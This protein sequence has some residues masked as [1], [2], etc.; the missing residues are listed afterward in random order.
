MIRPITFVRTSLIRR[1]IPDNGRPTRRTPFLLL[2]VAVLWSA[3]ASAQSVPPNCPA[4][5][6]TAAIID[7]DL[8][9][10]FCELCGPGTIRLEIENPFRRSDDADFSDIVVT[11]D[12]LA[13]GLTYV[14]GTTRFIGVNVATPPAVEPSVSG[15]NG[16][17]LTWTLPGQFVLEGRP[18]GGSGNSRGLIV[19]F[20][21][22]RHAA[23]GEEGLVLANRTIDAQVEFTP[24]CDTGYRH[25]STSGP[26]LLPLNEP[27]PQIIKTGRVVDAGQSSGSYTG[28]IYGHEND[29]AIWRIEVRNNGDA[30]L[31]DLLFSDAMQPGN[32]E[33]DHIC[34]SEADASSAAS[35][36]GTG[37]CVSVGGVTD[38]NDISVEQL[39]DT[40]PGPYIVAPAGGSGFYYLVGR[41]TDSC[42]NRTNTVYDVEWGCEVEPP[43]G[44]IT[45]TST[46]QTAG[47]DALLSTR[48]VAAGLDV[49][50]FLTGTNTSQPMGTKG[51]VRIR[52]RNQTGG[53]IKGGVS[54]LRLRN[55][56]PPEYVVDPTFDPIVR[57]SPAYGNA[58][59]G[60]LDTIEWTNP[61]PGTFPL[62][63]NDPALPLGNIAPEFLV[64]SSDV[65]DDFPDQLNMLRHGDTLNIIF[66]TVLIDPQ[67]YDREAYLDVRE[68][69]PA[70]DPPGTD[71]TETF[72]ID[73]QV[74]IWWEEFCTATEHY[75]QVNQPDTAEPEDIDVDVSGNVLNFILTNTDVL[76]L[77]AELRNRGGHDADDY[78]AYVTFGE[79]MSVQSAPGGCSQT[80][81]P[82]PMPEWQLPVGIPPTATVYE[83]DVGM[84]PAGAQRD[85]TFQVAKNPSPAADD[86]LTFRVDV[87]GEITLSDGT[88]LW[89]PTPQ[90]RGD[91]ITDRANNYTIDALR[92]RVVGYNLLKSQ[93]GVCTENNPPPGIPDSEI[94]IGEECEFHIESG[95]WFGFDTP[96][97]TYIAVQ[98]IQVVDRIPDGQGYISSTN[99]LDSGFSTTAI[100]GVS[101]NPPPLPLAEDPFDW[102]HNT[103]VPAQRI[104]VKD[105][106]FRVNATTRLLNDPV[107]QSAAPNQHAAL[108]RNLLTSSFDAVFFNP[109]TNAEEVYTL[110]PSTI[111]Y[112]PEFRRRVDLTVTEPRLI[113]EKHVCNETIYG[114]GPACGNFVPLADDGDAFDTY[115]YRVTV[116]NE[117]AAGGVTRAPA[118]DVTVTSD[119]DPTDLIFVDPLETDGLDN[120]GN[121]EIDEAAGEGQIVP[122][123]NVLNGSPAQ[124]IAAWDHSDALLRI[125]AGDSV[126]LYY[127]VDPFDDVAPLQRL[128]NSAFATYDSLE[129]DSGNQTDPLGANGEIGGAR[130]YTSESAE[131]TI[132]IIPVEVR[133]KQILRLSNTPPVASA[134]PQPVSIGEEV[135]FELR[136]LIPV[137]QLRNFTIRDELPAGMR[138]VEAP[139]VD[140]DAPPYDAAGF[141]PGGTFTPTC[142]ETEV[143]WS[144]GDQRITTSP[145]TDRRFD[146]GIQFIA[147]IDNAQANQDGLVI[148]NGGAYTVTTVTYM[149][150]LNNNVVI[151]FEAAEVVVA[152]PNL[153]LTKDFAVET[154]DA[155]DRLTVTVTAT[156]TGT[157]TAYNPRVL[158]DLSA[159]DLGYVG[160]VGGTNPPTGV[161]TTTYG[162]DSPLFTW[163]PGD[164]IAPG[165]QLSFTFVVEVADT[166]EP[167]QVLANT[168][169]ADWTSLPGQATALNTG[170]T[171]GNDGAVDGMRNGALPNAADPVNDYEA[172]AG[173]SVYVPPLAIAK[174]DLNAALAAEIGAHKAF[175]VQIDLPEG[176]SNSVSLTDDL[177][178]GA[179]SY[180]LSDNSDFDVTYEFV[181][182]ASIN[183][184]APGEA[185]F[186]AV[187]ADGASGTAVWDVGSVV[188][189]VEDDAAANAITPYIRANYFARINNDLVT[190]VGST[191]QNSATAYFTNGD[192][193]AQESVNDDTPS[194]IAT[195]PALM[196]TKAISNVTPGKAPGDPIALGD[197]VQY[198]LTIPN[199][200]NA[201]AHDVNI[202][203]TLPPELALYAGYTPIAQIN[204]IDVAGFSGVPAGAPDGPLVWGA[205]NND[206]S[207]EVAAGATLEVTY[208][209]ELRAA[210]DENI[211][212]TNIVWV[213]WTSLD[214]A[215]TYERTGAGCPTITP[216]DDYCFGPASADGTPFPVGPPDALIKANTQST[217]TI[218]ASFSYRITIPTTPH[219][220]PLHDVRII[221]DLGAS[222]A[223]LS[224]VS[225]A[226]VSGSGTYTPVN[227]GSN[228]NLVIEDTTDGI[229]IPIGEQI[230]LDVTVRLD[231]TTTNVAGLTFTNTATYTYNRLDN[232]A[233]TIL[234]GAP[235]TSPPMTIVEPEL[236]LEKTGPAQMQLGVPGTFTLNLHNVGDS[237]AYN[238]TIY[239]LLPNQADGGMCDA[240]PAQFTAQVF[241]AD[242]TTAVSPVLVQ[243]TDFSV[244]F[245]GDPDCN[246]TITLLTPAATIGADQR[247]VVTYQSWLDTDS[248]QGAS[249]TNVAGA[250]EWF[251]LDVTDASAL[252]YA[253]AYT[254]AVTDG[255]VNTLDH[256]D[257]HT[258]VVFSPVLIFEKY[259]INVTTGEDPATV[260]TPGDTIRYGLRIE[261]VSDTPLD[262]FSIVDELDNLN[263]TPM[264]RAG[265][266][267][268]VTLPDGADATNTDPNGGA[269]G[270][271]LLDIRDLSLGGVGV[272]LLVEFEIELKPVIA[273]GSIVLNQSQATF[274][275]FPVAVSD[276]PNV[277]GAADPNVAG[278]EDPTEVP[279]QSAPAFDIDKIST[280]M[281]GDPNVLLAGETLRYTIT[282][283]N[284]GTDNAAD[285]TIADQIPANTTYVAGSTTLNGGALADNASA[286]SPLTDGILINAPQDPTP[287]VMNAGVAD[288]IATITFD[289]VVYP[290]VPDG[291]VIS[292]QAF[293]NA[294][295]YGIAD[296]PSDDPRTAV[297]DDPTQ[298]V[299]GNFPLLFAPK[300]A[301]L[302]V[303]NGSPGIVDP[304]DTLR[305][306]IQIYNNGAVPATQAQL[307]DLVPN[308]VTYVPDSTMLNG[309]PVGVPDGGAFPLS[310]R[311]DVSSADLTPPLPGGSEGVLTPGESA[312]VQFD[313][314]VNAGVPTGTLITNQALV[315]TAEL[316]NLLTDGDGNAA[317]GPEPTVVVVGDAQQLSIAKDLAVV[318][319]GPAVAGAT[320]EYTV[321][322]RNVG[323]VPALYVVVTDDLDA[324]NPGYLSYVDQSAVMNGISDGVTVIGN[325]ITAD[326]AGVN[327]PLEPGETILLR[328][329]AVIDPNL[330]DGTPVS[331]T[332]VVTWNDPAQTASA[333]SIIDVGGV[334]GAGILSG[335]VWH[336]ADY[337]GTFGTGERPL[338]GW[339]VT[340]YRD[341]EPIRSMLTDADGQYVMIGVQPNYLNGAHVLRC[342]ARRTPTSP[343]ACNAS[344][345]SP[346]RAAATSGT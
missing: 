225:V 93:V 101:L 253:R 322:V 228:T 235:G 328:F 2:I 182:I 202:V 164:A 5:L 34:D 200:G 45:A 62:T 40:G 199:I 19:E 28:T 308:D 246:L 230:V 297:V 211:A 266:L 109:L 161:D 188:T 120:D 160:N 112:P 194:I 91:G 302:A 88:P 275:G 204:G 82:P 312:V 71:P 14:P 61:Q 148:G 303:D 129:R 193:G 32:F 331:N 63:T 309:E 181:G 221:D 325:V 108:S 310:N 256:E 166:V 139:D 215:S 122:D 46:G 341:G 280:Y 38:L 171:I 343:T 60:M 238:L 192:N 258:V 290:D 220:L 174:T 244:A 127:R 205:G 23:V 3:G 29:D 52:I 66:R 283:Q 80:T 292:N 214:D 294:P 261:N 300:S 316:P 158:D 149:D 126:T 306:T 239:D 259:A 78:F 165:E 177:A 59:Q 44:G 12:L 111:G 175:Q 271:G 150:E 242:G 36:G 334:P 31:Q 186:T 72:P 39:F 274:A 118:Y 55:L 169:Q 307:A 183:G 6:A 222:A 218:G 237:P 257:A 329:R 11:E 47:D 337:T 293:L 296:Q 24:S 27:E 84:I 201:I 135:E 99:P 131:A 279:I 208:R 20:Q 159:V 196:A 267:N 187:P 176:V 51:R 17:V 8:A 287:G 321:S 50:V 206:G 320:L 121:A 197:I 49:D 339:T 217:A 106:W 73:N 25:T 332:A 64:T 252:N 173:D 195:E 103:V 133:P 117:A 270:T 102:T 124:I 125:D 210:A 299:V 10:S 269:A 185:A 262:G 105:H 234:P 107:D 156:N 282:V 168:V 288:N 265:T 223:D 119:A 89:F 163:D 1:A 319:G 278:D 97:F 74:E 345:T 281:T 213:D 56:L 272:S 232:A 92:A 142:T 87:I 134:T 4:S 326:Y 336:D 110:G 98:D 69:E 68:E 273:N 251:S 285:V 255:T 295:G 43:P 207:L 132:Q 83:C 100:Q 113:V 95:G 227:T 155:A 157:A 324:D 333:T 340:L 209:V 162:P 327:G 128:T 104:T 311:I 144:F 136:T 86:D 268:V 212:L 147:R 277:N 304:G 248:Q 260:A 90:P 189:E 26:G 30:D 54:G 330:V 48:S 198:V 141:V 172:E 140:L 145:R 245:A 114:T 53:T 301:A 167:L 15:A 315:Y 291:T 240:P 116:T 67:Y 7:H 79:A 342:S 151:D 179:V 305:Y 338:E 9:V 226:L 115:I 178:F 152:E 153:E 21:V 317:T 286:T 335:A 241:E 346:C 42:T 284:I 219:P 58:Y 94:Q 75:L 41:I 313:M 138:C 16:S 323:A 236:T 264:F 13:S 263:A 318:G 314:Q 191:L 170:G 298:D 18:N 57:I 123:N 229:D 37:D 81:N 184:Q 344:T 190:N 224:Y 249:L 33:I 231:D 77:T 22:R 76:P 243:D 276:D 154:A 96:G 143:V 254:R 70:S 130:Q 233:A 180:F 289:V 65:H 250:T 203:D 146:F 137:A 35:G 247:L 85:L 216:P